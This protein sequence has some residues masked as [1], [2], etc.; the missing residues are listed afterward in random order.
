MEAEGASRCDRIKQIDR[1]YSGGAPGGLAL[2]EIVDAGDRYNPLFVS[3]LQ[4]A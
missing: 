4:C 1:Q 3:L 2:T